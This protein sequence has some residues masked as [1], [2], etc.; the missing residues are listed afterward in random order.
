MIEEPRKCS[1]LPW[2]TASLEIR[3]VPDPSPEEYGHLL[4]R[5][6]RRFGWQVF[7]PACPN[8][9]ACRSLR[10]LVRQFTPSSS[11]RRVLR[12]NERVRAEL[13]PLFGSREHIE[14]FNLY[15]RFMHRHRSWP[16][17]QVTPVS[18]REEFLSGG[19]KV[20]LQWLYFD[21]EDR[22]VGVA[23]MDEVPGAI[24]L[25]YCFYHPNWRVN[26]PGTFSV[27]NQLLYAKRRN[28]EYA[29]LGYWVE[30]CPSM[31]YKARFRPHEILRGY[32][33]DDEAPVWE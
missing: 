19:S 12:A 24:S 23:L 29:Y 26:S 20:G 15:H 3:A 10:V 7:R 4:A 8:C 16:L 31:S 17:Q 21:E 28:L 2:E 22:L 32:P 1:Y 5:G 9:S 27:L 6:Y 25:A 18:Y 14:L 13:H 30:A 33:A 11:Q